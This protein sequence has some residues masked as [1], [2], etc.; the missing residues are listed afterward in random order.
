MD[1]LPPV[2]PVSQ[3]H[4]RRREDAWWLAYSHHPA[5]PGTQHVLVAP[6]D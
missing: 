1:R 4:I 3:T 5:P 6:L 2:V